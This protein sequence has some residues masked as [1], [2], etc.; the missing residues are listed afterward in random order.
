VLIQQFWSTQP[1]FSL[2]RGGW[3]SQ[4]PG[5]HRCRPHRHGTGTGLLLGSVRRARVSRGT[6]LTLCLPPGTRS[7]P[8]A[9]T[10]DSAAE[11]L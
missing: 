3:V 7:P 2:L 9:E 4:L 1:C 5:E 11:R 8:L 10:A 6:A